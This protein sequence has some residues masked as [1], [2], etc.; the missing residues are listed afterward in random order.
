[1]AIINN[2]AN[3]ILG[4]E[5]MFVQGVEGINGV[6]LMNAM[7]L[8]GWKGGSAVSIPVNEDEYLQE[9]NKRRA[10]SRLKTGGDDKVSDMGS[11]FGSKVK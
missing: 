7:E 11:T 4:I 6:E 9:L 5:E 3:A 8:S 1:M 2:F 10:T